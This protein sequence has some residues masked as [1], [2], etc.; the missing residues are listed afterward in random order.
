MKI[1]RTY[2]DYCACGCVGVW[3]GDLGRCLVT[4]KT[5]ECHRDQCV[6]IDNE[7]NAMNKIENAKKQTR[8][9]L[10]L[11]QTINKTHKHR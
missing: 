11:F 9:S 1:Y 5:I 6:K 4:S 2:C 3:L 7:G 8:Y 10:F